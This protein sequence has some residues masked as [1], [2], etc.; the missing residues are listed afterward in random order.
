M[1]NL[2]NPADV[3]FIGGIAG[4]FVLLDETRQS[5]SASGNACACL[6]T[7]LTPKQAVI[8]VASTL[9]CGQPVLLQVPDIGSLRGHIARIIESGAAVTLELTDQ[10]RVSFAGKVAWYRKKVLFNAPDRRQ[11]RRRRP[12]DPHSVLLLSDGTTVACRV[13]DV[14][15]SGAAIRR[16]PSLRSASRWLLA[17]SSAG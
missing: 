4:K 10:E 2:P 7:S 6:V 11:Y 14:S 1:A 15:R 17:R 5:A 12:A 8:S 9:R 16:R 3:R 13:I